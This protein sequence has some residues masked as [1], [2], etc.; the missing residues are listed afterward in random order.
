M[1]SLFLMNLL[2]GLGIGYPA[3]KEHEHTDY[4]HY[5]N[6]PVQL[7]GLGQVRNGGSSGSR[8]GGILALQLRL[9]GYADV[10]YGTN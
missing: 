5:H 1:L 6:G 8:I 7:T 4:C 3:Q 10:V 2:R 9:D